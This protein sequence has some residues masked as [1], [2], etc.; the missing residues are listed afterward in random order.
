M[1]IKLLDARMQ[2]VHPFD[3]NRMHT[4]GTKPQWN[5]KRTG[6]NKEENQNQTKNSTLTAVRKKDMNALV[7]QH[8]QLGHKC[9]DADRASDKGIIRQLRL[10]KGLVGFLQRPQHLPTTGM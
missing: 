4:H 2:E 6:N 1:T 5:A 10:N 9:F 8:R 7:A 3:R